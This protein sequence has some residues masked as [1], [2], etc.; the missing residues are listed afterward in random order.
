MKLNINKIIYLVL[1]SVGIAL[2][3]FASALALIANIEWMTYLLL[4]ITYFMGTKLITIK[5]KYPLYL[6]KI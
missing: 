4:F 6:K 3:C 1:C 5:N 2:G